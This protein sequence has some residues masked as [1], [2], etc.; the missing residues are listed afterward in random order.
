MRFHFTSTVC[1]I[2]LL[3]SIIAVP[4]TDCAPP[5]TDFSAAVSRLPIRIDGNGDFT[6]AN[7]VTGGAGTELNPWIIENWDISGHGYGY[8][9]YIGNTTEHFIIRDCLIHDA[10][11]SFEPYYY[12]ESGI[13]MRRVSN[14]AVSGNNIYSND[15]DGIYLHN[16]TR[17]IISAN[18]LRGNLWGIVLMDFSANNSISGNTANNSLDYGIGLID[19]LDNTVSGNI[20][21]GNANTGI[22]LGSSTKNAITGNTVTGNPDGIYLDLSDGNTVA[23]NNIT[24]NTGFGIDL[25]HSSGNRIYHNNI[26]DNGVQARD[27]TGANTWDN[28]Y[29]SGGNHWSGYAGIDANLDGI[30]DTAYPVTGGMGTKDRYPFMLAWF[31]DGEA[32][33]AS[34]GPDIWT[35]EDCIIKFMGNASTDNVGVTSYS[36]AFDQGGEIITLNG[37]SPVH[38][39]TTPGI[40]T[41]TLEARDSAGNRGTD[42]LTVTVNDITPPTA[43]AGPDAVADIGAA[44]VL[45]GSASTDNVAAVGYSW[46]FND[47]NENIVLEGIIQSHI[48]PLAGEYTV[49]LNVSD[50]VGLWDSDTVLVTVRTDET[51]PTADAG[52]DIT[53]TVGGTAVFNGTASHDNVGIENYTW[54]FTYNGTEITLFGE[55]QTQRFW[56][57]GNYTVSLTV[58]DAAGNS[59]A[60]ENIVT[61]LANDTGPDDSA[62]D[63]TEDVT[64]TENGTL[65]LLPVAVMA[66]VIIV[67]LWALWR[68]K[69]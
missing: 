59:D 23:E 8:C 30:G 31:R 62:T 34:A 11:G 68:R 60:D 15:F 7:G 43:D 37:I 50:A 42:S 12:T 56:M 24:L 14:G 21:E 28:G 58:R 51:A 69:V 57:P 35:D 33:V 22:F 9:I 6:A 3:V 19:S 40:Y 2:L 45:N 10:R 16:S 4:G 1:I 49:T 65:W 20:V 36:W 63:D 41:V 47:G 32:P 38:N 64:E 48:F 26:L 29:P 55:L 53:I 25:W 17:N 27:D 46:T 67:A 66:I 13:I 39:F 5:A 52:V 18:V 44:V 54:E 61:V